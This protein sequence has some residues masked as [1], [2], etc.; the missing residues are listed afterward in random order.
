MRLRDERA[1]KLVLNLNFGSIGFL[2][3]DGYGDLATVFKCIFDFE[4]FLVSRL[5]A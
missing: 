1:I 3:L 2:G 4:G 5:R